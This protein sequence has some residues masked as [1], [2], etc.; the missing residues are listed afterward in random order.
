M[1]RMFRRGRRVMGQEPT[2]TEPVVVP[3]S[4]PENPAPVEPPVETP[5][6]VQTDPPA[7]PKLFDETY[8]KG[9]RT[10]NANHRI[11]NKEL[12]DRIDALERE[13]LSELDALKLDV[14]NF[15]DKIVPDLTRQ[16]Q[17][18]MV[19]VEAARLGI[20]DPEAASLLLDWNSINNG[21]PVS[22]ALANLVDARPW[23]K[24]AAAPVQTPPETPATPPAPVTP[25]T[26]TVSNPANPPAPAHKQYTKSQLSAMS[27]AQMAA[28][29]ADVTYALENGLVD[30]T[31]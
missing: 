30:M 4:T 9:L 14:S 15:K 1:P 28:E 16:N 27:S 23:L 11:K 24:Q 31:R 22:E 2:P 19:Q 20:V 18:L 10:E 13:K 25:Q 17:Q 12:Q 5:A 3:P 21:A 29:L 8:V 6:P 26:P 7:D